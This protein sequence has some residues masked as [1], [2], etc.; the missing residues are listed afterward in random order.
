MTGRVAILGV[1]V[2]DATFRGPRLPA[3]GETVLGESFALGPGGKGSN[4]AVAAARLG[5]ETHLVTR[6]GTGPFSALAHEVWGEAGVTPHLAPTET[7]TGAAMIFVEAGTGENAIVIT[8]GAAGEIGPADIEAVA[9]VIAGADVFLTQLE[10]PLAAARRALEIARAAGVTTILNPAPAAEL[11]DDLLALCDW[12]TPNESEAAALAGHPVAGRGE[13][14]AAGAALLARGAG[15]AVVTLGAEGA[16]LC[17]AGETTH[18]PAL[19]A[20]LVVETTGAGDAFNAGFATG[21]ARG[22]SPL[23]A[24]RLGTA[25]AGLAVTR[26]GAAAAMPRGAEVEALLAAAPRP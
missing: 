4:Q 7:S 18:V 1:F 17:T 8:P 22:H 15:G 11:P 25:V 9:E 3:M 5:A 6:L 13:A 2:A 20:G 26:P 21:L 23:E 14:A 24:V 16:L 12:I 19:A 10:Q